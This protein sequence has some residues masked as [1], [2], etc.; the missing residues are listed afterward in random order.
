MKQGKSPV[1]EYVAS[2]EALS[3]YGLEFISTS[4]KK[5]MKFV[6]GLKKYLKKS[7][8]LQLKLS[9][10]ELVDSALHL[11]AIEKE[12]DSGDD[13]E[14]R[15]NPN[16]KKFPFHKQGFFPSKKKKPIES[17]SNSQSAGTPSIRKCFNCGSPDHMIRA[18]LKPLFCRYCKNEGHHVSSCP[19]VPAN[20]KS[21]KL[22]VDKASGGSSQPRGNSPSI[23]DGIIMF[24]DHSI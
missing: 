4:Y 23:L 18:C 17:G 16:K 8:M 12:C 9:F 15:K 22:Y 24:C 14:V 1:S 5:N 13:V 2:F 11:E 7:L 20:A 3:K 6:S 19:T 21:G 10:E